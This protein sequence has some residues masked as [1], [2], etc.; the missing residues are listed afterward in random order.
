ML[1]TIKEDALEFEQEVQQ[2]YNKEDDV[3]FGCVAI[4]NTKSPQ[5]TEA[6]MA[7][8]RLLLSQCS[9]GSSSYKELVVHTLSVAAIKWRDVKLWTKTFRFGYSD[10]DST[11]GHSVFRLDRMIL[12]IRMLGFESVKPM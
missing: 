8:T 7:L 1:G 11:V 3:V 9:S 2:R 6:E 4:Y 12:A 5:P 10:I